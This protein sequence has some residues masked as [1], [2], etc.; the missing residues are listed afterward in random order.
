MDIAEYYRGIGILAKMQ[1]EDTEDE[2]YYW[3]GSKIDPKK[4]A[5]TKTVVYLG[6]NVL[7]T[8]HLAAQF[9]KV[10]KS[11]T[12]NVIV[13]SG[14]AYCCGY[15]HSMMEGDNK[16][17]SRQGNRTVETFRMLCPERVILWCPTCTRQYA[18]N[19]GIDWETEPYQVIHATEF[20]AQNIERLPQ[21]YVGEAC[22]VAVHEH[23][24]DE[25]SQQNVRDVKSILQKLKGV[26]VVEGGRLSGFGYH[27]GIHAEQ[28]NILFSEAIDASITNI[29]Q[30]VDMIVSIYHS[31]HRALVKAAKR[32]N[33]KCV[34]YVDLVAQRAGLQ[35]PDRFGYFVN[36][37]DENRIW[38]EV[39]SYFGPTD[40]D[41]VR[42]V[43]RDFL[44]TGAK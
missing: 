8:L 9:V 23:P 2:D 4:A 38:E 30:S 42:R 32:R 36:L 7:R 39:A 15:P 12:N 34:N 29:Q 16:V 22:T 28:P 21:V 6:C 43:I 3:V 24:D 40:E 1:L 37:G 25:V 14:P 41:K 20:L 11:L 31:C 19:V 13:L 18:T 5:G 33:I 27:C 35:I 17:G 10:V 44:V 26:D